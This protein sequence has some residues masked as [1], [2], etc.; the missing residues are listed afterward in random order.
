MAAKT[1]PTITIDGVTSAP[2]SPITM[3]GLA[4]DCHPVVKGHDFA[5][6]NAVEC[7]DHGIT[8]ITGTLETWMF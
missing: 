7:E 4:C 5:V 6:G 8:T 1:A 2:A 3:L